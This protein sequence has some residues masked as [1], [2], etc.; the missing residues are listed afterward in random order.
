MYMD[1]PGKQ[2]M[3][4]IPSSNFSSGEVAPIMANP[5]QVQQVP[6][7][8]HSNQQLV[9]TCIEYDSDVSLEME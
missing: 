7:Q 5:Q 6:T 2:A 3:A 4:E 1:V 8:V 9:Q